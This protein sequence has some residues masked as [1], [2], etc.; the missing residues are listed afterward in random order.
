MYYD[1]AAS[2]RATLIVHLPANARLFVDGKPTRSTSSVR[3]FF[4][5]PL[6]AGQNYHYDLR[7]EMNRDGETVTARRRVDVR[8]AK[9][10]EV[11]LKFSDLDE[12]SERPAPPSQPPER[13]GLPP[14]KSK[15]DRP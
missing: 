10:E 2:S 5:P 9:T 1:P 11:Y 12:S 3:R 6:E 7:A 14:V 13:K 15:A 8:P 4:S